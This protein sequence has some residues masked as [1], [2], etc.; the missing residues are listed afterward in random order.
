MPAVTLTPLFRHSREC[1][2]RAPCE[3]VEAAGVAPPGPLA[4][5]SGVGLRERAGERSE[6]DEATQ[7]PL[8]RPSGRVVTIVILALCG[9]LSYTSGEIGNLSNIG[10]H[11]ASPP[12]M[13]TQAG[14]T[15]DLSHSRYVTLDSITLTLSN[16]SR[17][18]IYLPMRGGGLHGSEQYIHPINQYA[19]DCAAIEAGAQ[20]VRGW[21]NLAGGC[22]FGSPCPSGVAGAIPW[23]AVFI[24]EPG[25]SVQFPVYDGQSIYPLWSP[26]AYR[27]G[28]LYSTTAFVASQIRWA[29][30]PVI[31]HGG[32]LWSAP[33]TLTAAWGYPP[34]YHQTAP[35]CPFV[36]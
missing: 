36:E 4:L 11:N 9:G 2:V 33:V 8:A 23:P 26:G 13:T 22:D 6:S 25:E 35:R 32:V 28:V 5:W 17:A 16:W 15:L 3:R 27:F 12:L 24:L 21:Q 31:P 30:P 14:V 10:Y 34:T 19:P 1:G 7:A 20:R 18:P 29:F